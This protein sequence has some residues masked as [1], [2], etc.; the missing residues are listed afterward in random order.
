MLCIFLGMGL[1]ALPLDLINEWRFRPKPMKED[2]FNRAKS[3]L[4]KQV[5]I[6]LQKGRKLLD[7]KMLSDKKSGC[8]GWRER[9]RVSR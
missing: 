3:K 6:L 5:E 9:R 4:A 7:D 1:I 8:G 2:E